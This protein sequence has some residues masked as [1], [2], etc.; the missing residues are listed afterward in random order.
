M[1]VPERTE[2]WPPFLWEIRE[3]VCIQ[4]SHKKTEMATLFPTPNLA[5]R[6]WE[7]PFL[8]H[9]VNSVHEKV[10]TVNVYSSYID[11]CVSMVRD[12]KQNLCVV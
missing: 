2:R 5:I 10:P 9:S 1:S 8:T 7:Y 3:S 12:C 6:R 11:L 4:N